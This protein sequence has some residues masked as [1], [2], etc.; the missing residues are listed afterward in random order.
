MLRRFV[1]ARSKNLILLLFLIRTTAFAQHELNFTTLTARDG[2]SSNTVNAILKDRYGLMWFGTADGLN[3]FDGT[4]VTVYRHDVRDTTSLP[5]NEVMALYEDASGRLWIATNGGGLTF[6]DRQRNSFVKYP[7]DGSWETITTTTVRAFCQDH[8]GNLWVATYEGLR[9]LSLNTNKIQTLYFNYPGHDQPDH[10][11]V[12]LFEDSHHRMWVGTSKGL[13]LYNWKTNRFTHFVHQDADPLSL[14]GNVIKT[15]REDQQGNLWFGTF[16]G[17]NQ[18]LPDG[19]SFRAFKHTESDPQ[20]L[21]HDMVYAIAPYGHDKLWLGTEDGLN[22]LDLN[23]SKIIAIKPNQR[24]TFSLTNKSVRSIF[25]DKEGIAWLGTFR[26]GVNKY[27]KNLALFSL[28]KSNAFDRN[29]LTAPIVTA[30]AE[31]THERIF[32][33]TD[34]GG[35]HLFDRKSG[36]FTHYD[37]KPSNKRSSNL[38]ILAIELD[39]KGQL[40]IGTYVN[41]LFCLDPATGKYQ[42]FLA[43]NTSFDIDQND[44]FCIKEDSKGNIWIGTNG[45]GVN[46]YDPHSRTFTKISRHP[47]NVTDPVL[48]LNGFMRTITEDAN[49][50]IWLGSSGTGIA[51]YHPKTRTFSSY[52]KNNSNLADDGVVSILHDRHHRTWVG[53]NGG[54][55]SLF[56]E[57][58]HKFTS[59][60]EKD[61]LANG[62]VY[63]ILEDKNGMIWLSTDRGISC[64]NPQTHQFK[65]FS[66]Y[67]GLQDSPFVM[68]SGLSASDGELFFG[69][70][71]GFNYFEPTELPANRNIPAVILTDLKVANTT[72]TPADDAP[73][74]T[75]ISIAKEIHLA[76]GQ[77]FSISYVALNYTTPHQNQYSYK[78]DGFDKEWNF[79]GTATTAYYT[80]LNPGNYVFQVRASNNEGSWNAKGT[81]IIIKVLPP[82][83]RTVYAYILYVLIFIGLLFYLRHRGIQKIKRKFAVEQEKEQARALFEQERREVERLHELDLL[84]IKFLTN[85]SHEFRTPI[86]LILAPADTLLAMQNDKA[87]TGQ[88]HM[89]KRNAKR[90]LNLVNQLLD[91][92][93]MEENE[94]KLSLSPGD[95]V[96]FIKEAADSFQDLSERK[97][98]Q[99]SVISRVAHVPACFDH[100]KIER[101]VFNLLS[102]AFK[103][104]H[105]GGSIILELSLK[106]DIAQAMTTF[107]IQVTD[108]GIGISHGQQDKIFE[109]FFQND[110]PDS[111]LNQ[112][113]GIGLSITKEFVQLHGGEISVNS[114]LGKGTTFIINLPVISD[115]VLQAEQPRVIVE[116]VTAEPIELA[117]IYY[118]AALPDNMATV[119]L[120]EDNDDFRF[121]LKDNLKAYYHIIEAPNGKEGWQKALSCHPQ[122]IVSDISMPY[123]NGIELSRKI[124][125]DKRTTHIPVILL[126]AITGEQD[127]IIG[128]ESGAND[129]LTKPFNFEILNAKIRNLLLL[130]RTLKDTYSKQ[131]QVIGQEV[132]IESSDAKLLNNIVQYIEEKLNDPELSVEELSRHVGMS[133]GSLYHK[134]LEI[135]GL[136][137]VEYIRSV[138]LDKAATLLEKSDFNVAQIAYMTGFGTPSYFSKMF[139]AKFKVQ[140]SEY[141]NNKRKDARFRLESI[142]DNP[143]EN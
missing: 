99:L 19:K 128:L 116:Q 45:N 93:K 80:N 47:K 114:E 49:G 67:N 134:L 24:S 53:T 102:N 115:L 73:I 37:I 84:K 110:S 4:N 76:Y 33:G 12:S 129:Y 77:N 7:G 122:L 38:S 139:K 78:L 98:I 16:S 127:Q 42:Q 106:E 126:T 64:F 59:Y 131:I 113:S 2:L 30:F 91:F 29:G 130:N 22:I 74:R 142:T 71:D 62:F 50:D 18:L 41:G 137:P 35:L 90:L 36:L 40:W 61:G 82:I 46:I 83:Y 109:R 25:I 15:I 55:I 39:K 88:V 112:G 92:R 70:Q 141:L 101:I 8:L 63:K 135:T 31:Y 94:L 48:P 26:G 6:Y 11:I 132:K 57:R 44:I 65:N 66:R 54:G 52:N 69:G 118:P 117:G 56:N 79:V 97:K 143:S 86:S 123:M 138:K 136:S 60:S 13:Y 85:L 103:F 119:L 23:T 105:Q 58:T 121:Y 9:V 133:R 140:P 3:K 96:A 124:K 17:L 125:A 1:V 111:I 43:G 51:V 75:H 20:S 68:G 72:V 32:V 28:V 27:D 5:A 34:G 104:T 14:S 10:V 120:I 89:I 107:C 108:T 87:T 100:D 81:T 95:L 21:S